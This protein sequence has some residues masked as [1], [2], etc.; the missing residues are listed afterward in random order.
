[1][2][3]RGRK[4]KS[5]VM[6]ELE[7]TKD[8]TLHSGV[9]PDPGGTI[10]PPPSDLPD[11]AKEFWDRARNYLN[12]MGIGKE[13]DEFGLYAASMYWW[14]LKQANRSLVSDG[15]EQI[16]ETS[17]LSSRTAAATEATQVAEK[18]RLWYNE[19]GFVPSARASL[20]IPEDPNQ[21][22]NA[23]LE[24]RIFGSKRTGFVDLKAG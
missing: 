5:T 18:L 24:A 1:M 9:E 7:N 3:K 14:R 8:T 13:C 23:A 15:F 10:G 16:S 21:D 22:E 12:Q 20:R 17:G 19:V 11:E 4:A 2:A 6:H